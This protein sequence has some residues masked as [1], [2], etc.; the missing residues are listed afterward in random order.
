MP[1]DS[2]IIVLKDVLDIAQ[3]K[4]K[5]LALFIIIIIFI[6]KFVMYTNHILLTNV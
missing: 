6:S 3:F 1:N 2:L 5:S 4:I